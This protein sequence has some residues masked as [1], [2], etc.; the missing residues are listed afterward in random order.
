MLRANYKEYQ[1][2]AI[3]SLV[4]S[5]ADL[6][7][8][9]EI[10]N[11]L[12]VF[13]S[14]TGSG[15]TYI[16]TQFMRGI[17]EDHSE[18]D[19]CFLWISIGKGELHKQ[20]KK[21][22]QKILGTDYRCNV[23]EETFF[24]GRTYI[25][26]NELVVAN[27]EKLRGKN[28]KTGEWTNKLMRD[29]ENVNFI[30][31]L[32]YT[33]RRRKIIL[34]IDESHYASDTQRTNELRQIV[35]ADVTIE[36]SATPKL[37][38]DAKVLIVVEPKDVIDEGMIKKEIII[39][40]ALD[41]LVDDEKTSQDIIIESAYNK[42]LELKQ[43]FAETGVNI[44]PLCLIQLPNSEAGETK[45]E[46][47]AQFLN[48]KGIT[49]NNGK[50]AV[51]LSEEKSDGLDV[52]SD[53][54]SEVE[55]LIFKQAIDTGWDCPRAHILVKL[56][57][58]G[59]YTFEVQT[60]GR[61]LRMPEQMH[62]ENEML[63]RGYIYTN[64]QSITIAKEDYNPNI[65]K[66]LKAIR[67]PIY[68]PLILQSYY[69]K[70]VDFGDITSSFVTTLEKIF[71]NYFG[72][73]INPTLINTA[74]NCQKVID[75]FMVITPEPY[76]ERI[77][78]DEI[79]DN[80]K[81][82]EL[83]DKDFETYVKRTKLR[84]S[85]GDLGIIFYVVIRKNLNG[86][87]PKRSSERVS[88]AIYQ[89]FRKYLGI[90]Y[91][92]S[93]GFIHIQNLFL[94]PSNIAVYSRLLNEATEAYKPAKKQE[95]KEKIE[96]KNYLW[97]VK[98]EEFYNE[99]TDELID[100]KLNIY[101]KCYLSKIR[102]NPEKEFE[103]Y[104]ETKTEKIEWWF[105]NGVNK[106]DFFGVRYEEN[107]MPKTFYPDYLVQL[108]NGQTLIVDTKAGITAVEAKSRAEALYKYIATEN[109]KGKKLTGGILVQQGDHWKINRN[110]TY[111]YDKNDLTNWRFLEDI[112]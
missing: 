74:E 88:S 111:L 25:E 47:V 55:F 71:C 48:T 70:R 96:E 37:K 84:I 75:K 19:V 63:N 49:E 34:I 62:Y 85:D 87:A 17:I 94:H 92:A 76:N 79:I 83:E 11:K 16:A 1:N 78:I 68:K 38:N 35:N 109:A 46:A 41:K 27:W 82:D 50:L 18:N 42:R 52:I 97:E 20:S 99:H 32:Q 2:K 12:I 89:W 33:K 103:K 80:T 5:T 86:F 112:I 59:S 54:N 95:V 65:I 22:I 40:E 15:K 58:T 44:N 107:D 61:I 31:V 64:L 56:R 45:K 30:E 10:E 8:K 36:M 90:D 23:L 7:S 21:S 100:S 3:E 26:R 6:I 93:N 104:L 108:K 77:I 57:E 39:N 73:E 13:Q 91:N 110:E 105:K 81:F 28:K 102:S 67:K 72:M 24:G 98:F 29:S 51:W 4:S 69:K 106:Q 43:A 101:D 9:T 66:H 60:V 53:F 14:P